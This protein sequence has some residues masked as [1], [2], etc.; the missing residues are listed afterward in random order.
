MANVD[1]LMELIGDFGP[2]QKKIV[3][4]C[5]FPVI[6][7]AFV[8]VGVVFLGHTPDHWCWTPGSEQLLEECGWTEV[9][10]R[11]VTVPHCE[12]TGSFCRCQRFAVNLSSFLNKCDDFEWELSLN[13]SQTMP[14]D[15]RWIFDKSYKT[16][17]SEFSLV[18]EKAWL[19]DLNQVFL[20]FGFFIGAFVTSYIADRFGR[21]PCVIG[22]MLGL[23]IAGVGVSL[24]PWYPLLLLMR[25]LQGFCGKGAWTATYVLVVEFFGAENRKFVSMVSRTFYSLG[26]VILPGLAYFLVSWRNLQLAMSLPCFLFLSYYWIVPE[27]PR[28]LFSQGRKTD[29]IKVASNIAKCNNRV[30]PPNLHEI[31]LWEEKK[32]AP[33]V[34]FK[35][36]FRTPNIRKN[37]LILTYA[38]FTSTV[39][40]QGLVLR[41][42]ITGGNLLLD[43]F[44]SAVVEL[45][46]GLIFYLLVDR[47]GRRSLMAFTNLTAG[48]ACLLVPF[49]SPSFFWLGK[50]VAIIGRLAVA[51]GFET[52]NF[53]NTE[54]YPTH[55][56]NVGLSVCSSASDIGAIASPFLLYKLANIWKE[57]PLILYGV[58][59]V[60]YSALVT[61]LPEMS[62]VSLPETI[63]D[64]E[65]LKRRR[66]KSD[67]KRRQQNYVKKN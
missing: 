42:G 50:S 65:N 9:K 61:L 21:K 67:K 6:L 64:V 37:T 60:L 45:P 49:I 32:E 36:L 43:F 18:C 30:L 34:S 15:G 7:F 13:G 66:E 58:M 22:S 44:I 54:M 5:S 11:E 4:L 51:I 38:W 46:T 47:V 23:G 27:S 48:I 17:V 31:L 57:L 3:I 63:E 53:A 62:G 40:F 33:S 16:T 39:V 1:R 19:A 59:S 55:L 8:F 12:K 28:W 56:R 29:A 35:D 25:F 14:C 20:A 2:F 26:M 10:V 41:L 52:V 24:S